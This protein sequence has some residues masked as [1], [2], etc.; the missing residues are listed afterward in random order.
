M[1]LAHLSVEKLRMCCNFLVRVIL[2]RS[3]V[4][5]VEW[6]NFPHAEND[7]VRRMTAAD[8][9]MSSGVHRQGGGHVNKE[10][11]WQSERGTNVVA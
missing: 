3:R 2:R 11:L 4:V 8:S 7:C 10:V 1:L 6:G 5:Q 9:D